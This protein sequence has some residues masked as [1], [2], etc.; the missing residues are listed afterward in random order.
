MFITSS[1]FAATRP[2]M[3]GRDGIHVF[4]KCPASAGQPNADP[5]GRR[6][7]EQWSK[8]KTPASS[9]G[10]DTVPQRPGGDEFPEGFSSSGAD[11]ASTTVTGTITQGKLRS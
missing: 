1:F 11:S 3:S 7:N 4:F 6:E 10:F 2:S 5:S 9:G 8:K